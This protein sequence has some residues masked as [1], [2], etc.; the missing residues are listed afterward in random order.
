[1]CME[2]DIYHHLSL[3]MIK[4][5]LQLLEA[6]H[7]GLLSLLDLCTP[8]MHLELPMLH[9]ITLSLFLYLWLGWF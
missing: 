9:S 4:V 7:V 8:V 6:S 2:Q 1:M 5:D 3:S